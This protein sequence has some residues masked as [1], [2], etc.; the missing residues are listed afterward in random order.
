MKFAGT[1]FF[2]LALGF[3]EAAEAPEGQAQKVFRNIR[4]LVIDVDGTPAASR[5][6]DLVGL[7]RWSL[8]PYSDSPSRF[9]HFRTNRYGRAVV[10]IGEF[11]GWENNEERPGWGVYALVVAS[12]KHDAG[13]VSSRFWFDDAPTHHGYEPNRGWAPEWGP[14]VH[15][16]EE[17]LDLT[18]T[19]QRGFTLKGRVVDDQHP[20][21]PLA[22]MEI[23]TGNDLHAETHTGYGGAIFGSYAMTDAQ[24]RF[25]L[26]H[27]FPNTLYVNVSPA[28]WLKT[29]VGRDWA[30]VQDNT[31]APPTSG[32]IVE[33]N[34]GAARIPRFRYTGLIRDAAGKPVAGAQVNFQVMSSANPLNMT[35]EESHSAQQA[36][37]RS[38]G[39]YEFLSPTPWVA[40][41][42][43]DLNGK[44]GTNFEKSSEDQVLAPGEYDLMFAP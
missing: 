21:V 28:I 24:G 19:L 3:L 40:G 15:V 7:E 1:F 38:D 20:D 17:G 11:A 4:V 13:G 23:R 41:I 16:P 30:E 5:Q 42:Y 22:G 37:T 43:V 14:F 36:V 6:M 26:P 10:P 29:Q 18:I 31:V 12:G 32:K 2:L 35:W 39:T 9:W 44:R 33:L 27:Q 25:S 34:I 8:A